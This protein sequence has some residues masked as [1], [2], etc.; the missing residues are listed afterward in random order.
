[1]LL[2]IQKPLAPVRYR[3]QSPRRSN[4]QPGHCIAVAT[5]EQQRRTDRLDV[6]NTV[7]SVGAFMVGAAVTAYGFF[8][9]SGFELGT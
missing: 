6:S 9:C 1:M 4:P 8:F 7:D 5:V 3:T 2:T